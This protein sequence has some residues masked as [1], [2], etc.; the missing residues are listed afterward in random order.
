MDKKI[1]IISPLKVYFVGLLLYLIIFILKP[2]SPYYWG[3]FLGWTFLLINLIT[4]CLGIVVGMAK[5]F[6]FSNRK[7]AVSKNNNDLKRNI[8]T[9][10]FLSFI[11][12]CAFAIENLLVSGI[13]INEGDILANRILAEESEV[14]LLSIIAAIFTPFILVLFVYSFIYRKFYKKLILIPLLSIGA[15]F[16]IILL[17]LSLGSRSIILVYLFTIILCFYTIINNNISNKAV[18]LSIL[19]MLPLLMIF[20]GMFNEVRSTAF[21]MDSFSLIE[22]T[23]SS[24][25]FNINENIINTIYSYRFDNDLLYY[26]FIGFLNFTQYYTHGLFELLFLIEN[27]Q[28]QSTMGLLNFGVIIKFFNVVGFNID[29]S[30]EAVRSGTF[31]T[32]FGPNYY[33]FGFIGGIIFTFIL[34]YAYGAVYNH[35][36]KYNSISI[37]PLYF[38]LSIIFFFPMVVSF[39]ISA[40]GL[41]FI[42]SFLIAHFIYKIKITLS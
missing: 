27:Y 8:Y 36:I 9:M 21:G 15:I 24:F 42:S 26:L 30:F 19:V 20:N 17:S 28:E 34:S 23:A 16:F 22:K 7:I 3:S 18:F 2:S 10:L 37:I 41:Y 32:L 25:F 14:G 31:L 38:H 39:F 13:S 29:N 33:D 6:S 4:I 11:G 1:N 35:L 40:Q 12:F 5:N